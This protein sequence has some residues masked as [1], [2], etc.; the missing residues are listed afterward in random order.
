MATCLGTRTV[1]GWIATLS[2]AVAGGGK[3]LST[4]LSIGAAAV[5]TAWSGYTLWVLALGAT[6]CWVIS[7]GVACMEIHIRT[8]G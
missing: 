1:V 3:G 8:V 4:D 5:T 2:L 7:S 6:W